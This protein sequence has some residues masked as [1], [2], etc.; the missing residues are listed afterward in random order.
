MAE[1]GTLKLDFRALKCLNPF[2]F[3]RIPFYTL[4]R[5]QNSKNPVGGTDTLTVELFTV[6]WQCIVL[7]MHKQPHGRRF[8]IVMEILYE[9][10]IQ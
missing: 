5:Y 8:I 4:Q 9:R 10:T 7:H 2:F 1:A 3:L 6:K